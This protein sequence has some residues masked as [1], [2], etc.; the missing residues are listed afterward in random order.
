MVF[1]INKSENRLYFPLWVAFI[2]IIFFNINMEGQTA[3]TDFRFGDIIAE[4]EGDLDGDGIAERVMIFDTNEMG[5]MGTVRH[6]VIYKN[7]EERWDYWTSSRNAILESDAGGMMGDPF[8]HVEIEAGILHI[9]HYGGS[10]WKWS[11]HHKYRYQNEGFYL[12]GSTNIVERHCL[13]FA[14]TDF[15]LSTGNCVYNKKYFSDCDETPQAGKKDLH[16][17]LTIN[18][19]QLPTLQNPNLAAHTITSPQLQ[20]EIYYP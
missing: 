15:N 11:T 18:L 7:G 20:V 8:H 4:T 2:S 10:S 12:I 16:E 6:L 17:K 14:S 3:S 13:E 9:Y 19:A 1:E 5:D